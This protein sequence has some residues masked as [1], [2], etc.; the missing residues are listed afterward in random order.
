MNVCESISPGNGEETLNI[1]YFLPTTSVCVG[2]CEPRTQLPDGPF[3]ARKVWN[4]R[5][6][7]MNS[8][9]VDA[10]AKLPLVAILR[11]MTPA[12]SPGILR[13]LLAE[14]FLLIEAPLNSPQPYESI[15]TMRAIAPPEAFVGAGTVK[16]SA[17]VDAVAKVGG[18]LIVM[19]HADIGVVAAAKARGLIALPGVA[20]PTEAFAALGAGADGLKAF[21]AEMITPS[22]VKAWRAVIPASVPIMP[23]GGVTP[24]TMAPYLEAGANGF[25]L[26]SALYRPGDSA[27][28]VREKAAAFA[29]AWRR[30]K[31]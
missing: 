23:V 27:A 19:P 18:D 7:V 1:R 2:L 30:L 28:R 4:H 22:V 12:E 11:G 9:F 21:P 24:E 26:G 29:A 16:T 5:E 31:G 8:R 10:M 15:R 13:A 6:Q 20:T 17:E 25:G 14:G 3:A